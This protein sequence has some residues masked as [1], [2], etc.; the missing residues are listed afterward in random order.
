MPAAMA[1][2]LE[3]ST[4]KEPSYLPQK[5]AGQEM[6]HIQIFVAILHAQVVL[7]RQTWQSRLEDCPYLQKQGQLQSTLIHYKM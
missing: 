5:S 2:I 3:A 6:Q 1:G 7:R 4:F